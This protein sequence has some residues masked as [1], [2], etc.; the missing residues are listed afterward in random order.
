MNQQQINEVYQL[1]VTWKEV[2]GLKKQ[3]V[4]NQIYEI[5]KSL[6]LNWITIIIISKKT[7]MTDQEILSLSWDCFEF[8]LRSY[9]IDGSIPV[10]HHFH[11]YTLFFMKKFYGRLHRQE[12]RFVDID[13]NDEMMERYQPID[14]GFEKFYEK[15][16][17]IDKFKTAVVDCVGLE[18]GIAFDNVLK[19]MISSKKEP[20]ETMEIIRIALEIMLNE[21][22]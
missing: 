5:M 2:Y 19:G 20:N 1:I 9:K 6:I 13:F 18:G 17:L 15:L 22:K 8:C 7:T 4:R 11:K 10:P 16:D 3:A 21:L 14:E 12:T